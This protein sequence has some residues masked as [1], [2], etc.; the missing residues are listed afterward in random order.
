MEKRLNDRL[1][2]RL[3]QEPTRYYLVEGW[4]EG[5]ALRQRIMTC[6]E[7]ESDA[8]RVVKSYLRLFVSDCRD[9]EIEEL[10]QGSRTLWT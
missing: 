1:L 9:W 4:M 2:P 5:N 7:N 6:Y 3:N 8:L 10:H